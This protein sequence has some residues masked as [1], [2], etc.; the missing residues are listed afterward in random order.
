MFRIHNKKSP[1]AA[2]ATGTFWKRKSSLYY[3]AE[4]YGKSPLGLLPE[5]LVQSNKASVPR[6]GNIPP[7][8]RL[9][10]GAALLLGVGAFCVSARANVRGELSKGGGQILLLKE[11][12]PFKIQ[13][14]KAGGVGKKAAVLPLG[15]RIKLHA[16]GGVF[17][18]LDAS[19]DL[20]RL[21]L[22]FGEQSVEQGGFSHARGARKRRDPAT[23]I[24]LDV[25][26]Q[27]VGIPIQPLAKDPKARLLVA[28]AD[29][30]GKI[31]LEVALGDHDHRLNA[32]ELGNRDQL[33][34]RFQ[35]RVGRGGGK[36]NEQYVQ[37]RHWRTDQ[38]VFSLA[39][40][41][42]GN[43]RAVSGR[44]HFSPLQGK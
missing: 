24:V 15:Q 33:V 23:E 27:P 16:T 42:N 21:Q 37:I 28:G 11:I 10:N 6:G 25:L 18:S 32:V 19:A 2:H 34:H 30:L 8:H 7:L 36:S 9:Q 38:R 44:D 12:E 13:H 17:S 31:R 40:A 1:S 4:Y 41:V 5:D 3:I 39:N 29:P 26:L 20:S 22:Q 14:G 35:N 43:A